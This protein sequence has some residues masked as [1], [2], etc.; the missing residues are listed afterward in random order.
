MGGKMRVNGFLNGMS[1][2]KEIQDVD[3]PSSAVRQ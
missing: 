1:K 3:V 2:S